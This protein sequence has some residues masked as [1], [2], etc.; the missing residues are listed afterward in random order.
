MAYVGLNPGNPEVG[1]ALNRAVWFGFAA[2]IALV[3]VWIQ[4]MD[5]QFIFSLGRVLLF[6][7]ALGS[8]CAVVCCVPAV[9]SSI[10]ALLVVLFIIAGSLYYFVFGIARY[11]WNMRSYG[12]MASEGFIFAIFLLSMRRPLMMLFGR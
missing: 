10:H 8:F 11:Y 1:Y 3:L 4:L 12:D 7:S 5:T 9:S 6:V 2:F